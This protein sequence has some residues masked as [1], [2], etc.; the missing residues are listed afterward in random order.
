MQVS[1]RQ[2][3]SVLEKQIFS[4]FYQTL[5]DLRTPE[6]I[7]TVLTDLLTETELTALA[8]RLAIATFLEKGRSYE[9][10]RD[11]L[12]VSSATIASVAEQIGNPGF[13]MALERIRAEEW[14]GQ[15]A[16]RITGIFRKVSSN[17]S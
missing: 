17:T 13:Q 7:K 5:S 1:S 6:E 4:V 10:I 12:K 11:T 2:L 3:N 15:W 16:G 8:K 9:N 14:A